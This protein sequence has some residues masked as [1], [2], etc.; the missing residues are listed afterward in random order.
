MVA[1]VYVCL[2]MKTSVQI[3]RDIQNFKYLVITVLC[4]LGPLNLSFLGHYWRSRISGCTSNLQPL[5]RR[6][7]YGKEKSA[8]LANTIQNNFLSSFNF[9]WLTIRK[10][11]GSSENSIYCRLIKKVTRPGLQ[12][13][14]LSSPSQLTN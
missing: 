14:V 13:V 7:S 5:T 1:A 11:K 6:E 4:Q 8:K 3:F 12:D 9:C 2:H 10:D